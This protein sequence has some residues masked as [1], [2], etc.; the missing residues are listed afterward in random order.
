MAAAVPPT[1]TASGKIRC[2]CAAEERTCSHSGSSKVLFGIL[3][4]EM[5]PLCIRVLHVC[6]GDAEDIFH[7]GAVFEGSHTQLGPIRPLAA[8]D[9]I[10]DCGE[11]IS[12]PFLQMPVQHG[13]A[14]LK[15]PASIVDKHRKHSTE[16][17]L[18]GFQPCSLKQSL[19]K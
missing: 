15:T 3:P 16:K 19:G 1:R 13:S 11:D 2:R 7:D 5:V 12:H 10:V 6:K 8:L 9:H 4:P 18:C 17:R 14:F